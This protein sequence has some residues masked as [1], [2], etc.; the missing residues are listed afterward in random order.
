MTATSYDGEHL[1]S[2]MRKY[3]HIEGRRRLD[4]SWEEIWIPTAST[5]EAFKELED[6]MKAARSTKPLGLVITGEADTGKSRTMKAFRD[7]HKPKTNPESEFAE[8]PAVYINSPDKPNRTEVYKKILAEIGHPI[9]YNAGEEDLH[10]HTLNMIRGCKVGTIMIDELHDISRERMGNQTLEFLR[11]LKNFINE[12]GRP[13]VVGGVPLILGLIESDPQ[14]SGR[15]N[16]VIRLEPLKIVDFSKVVLSYEKFM[17]L[18]RP[19]NF[20]A[21]ENAVQFLYTH[22]RGYIGLLSKLLKN[23]SKIAIDS[24]EERITLDI[25]QKVPDR[26]IHAVGHREA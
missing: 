13:F 9:L 22:S 2:E 12:T 8:F 19:T 1:R 25:L 5:R 18:R 11:F 20:R 26:S 24:G 14:L 23:A 4:D 15:L 3:L 16:T 21:D 7:E 17:P 6:C 10:R